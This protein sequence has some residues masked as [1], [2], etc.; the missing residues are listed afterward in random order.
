MR[1]HFVTFGALALVVAFAALFFSG[2]RESQPL[3]VVASRV[4][5][6]AEDLTAMVPRISSATGATMGTSRRV[7]YLMACSGVPKGVAFE[8]HATHAAGIAEK[9]RVTPREAATTVL[10]AMKSVD[11]SAVLSNC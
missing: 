2:R 10:N 5:L 9:Q 8:G 11:G 4:G 7:V 6:S 1:K 3:E